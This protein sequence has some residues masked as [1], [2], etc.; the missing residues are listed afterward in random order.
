[1]S[2]KNTAASWLIGISCVLFVGTSFG[3]QLRF[4]WE[5]GDNWSLFPN[6]TSTLCSNAICQAGI[7]EYTYTLEVP[8]SPGDLVDA[9]VKG[10]STTGQESSW[11]T[12][13]GHIP[14]P[15]ENIQVSIQRDLI[16]Q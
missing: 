6:V 8:L 13:Q 5:P 3:I 10:V 4:A 1:M 2:I 15:P 7:A 14:K 9:R 12:Y 16:R 11:C